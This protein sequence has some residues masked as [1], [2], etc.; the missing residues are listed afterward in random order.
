MKGYI[1]VRCLKLENSAAATLVFDSLRTGFPTTTLEC[2][3]LGDFPEVLVELREKCSRENIEIHNW[4]HKFQTNDQVIQHLVETTNEDFVAIDSDVVFWKAVEWYKPTR[5]L[6]G[7]HIPKHIGPLEDNETQERL[8]TSLLYFTN[9]PALRKAILGATPSTQGRFTD[10]QPFKPVTVA[11]NGVSMFFDSCSVLYH[12]IGGEAFG[13]DVL[14]CYDHLH[15]GSFHDE[16]LKLRPEWKDRYM[17][18]FSHIESLK[19][20]HKAQRIFW[21]QGAFREIQE[22]LAS[23]IPESALT[24]ILGYGKYVGYIDDLIDEPS[25]PKT[26]SE[27]TSYAAKLFSSNY[28]TENSQYLRVIEQLVHVIY[29]SSLDWEKAPEAWKRR[30]ARVLSHCGYYMILAVYL[31]E[32]RDV[33]ATK[34]L[35]AKLLEL[36][37]AEHLEDLTQLELFS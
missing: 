6:A 31:H 17:G 3:Y 5:M 20:A 4:S 27:T 1:I 30:D 29:F 23:R 16:V 12:T 19:G 32:T 2:I 11:L 37:H 25:N 8:H 21:Y 15:Y 14:D 28:W 7:R 35:A 36:N 26:V 24:F 13:K 18:A 22:H 34:R 33:E 9:L 10:F